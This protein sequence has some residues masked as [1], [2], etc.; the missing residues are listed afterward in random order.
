M[1]SISLLLSVFIIKVHFLDT[2]RCPWYVFFCYVWML[3]FIFNRWRSSEFFF[4]LE[5]PTTYICT[6]HFQQVSRVLCTLREEL[7]YWWFL[8]LRTITYVKLLLQV[9][10]KFYALLS[11]PLFTVTWCIHFAVHGMY[12]IESES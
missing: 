5:N 12:Y 6:G 7:Q 11:L 9:V 8:H 1:L 10:N 2:H 4:F 3:Q